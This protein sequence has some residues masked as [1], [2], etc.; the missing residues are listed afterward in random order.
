MCDLTSKEKAIAIEIPVG[1]QKKNKT[2]LIKS[3]VKIS[4]DFRKQLKKRKGK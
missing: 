2:D 3:L 4:L 1:M